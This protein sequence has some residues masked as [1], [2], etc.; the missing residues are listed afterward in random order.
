VEGCVRADLYSARNGVPHDPACTPPNTAIIVGGSLTGLATAIRLAHEGLSVTVLERGPKFGEG[1]GL[2]VDRRQLS[3]VI[4]VSAFGD[5]KH[6]ALPVIATGRESTSWKAV[7]GWLRTVALATRGVRLLT[8][9]TVISVRSEDHHAIADTFDAR[10]DADLLIGAD[11]RGSM[12]R[13]FVAPE[14]RE[15]LYSGYGLWRG[16]IDE[17]DLPASL[18]H[19]Y[20]SDGPSLRVHPRYRL[21]S[22]HVPGQDGSVAPGARAVS[23]AW[24]DPDLTLIFE[25]TGCVRSGVVRRSL[26][27]EE[28]SPIL[29]SRL[30][31]LA[32]EL[33][34]DPIGRIIRLTL[35][36]GRTF[37]TPIAEYLPTRLTSG[38]LVLVGDAAHLATPA[39]SAGLVSGLDD[40]EAL[41][42]AVRSERNG[43]LAALDVYETLRLGPAQRLA[44]ASRAWSRSYLDQA[45]ASAPFGAVPSGRV[46]A[47]TRSLR[48]SICRKR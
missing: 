22:Y 48:G 34:H 26:R 20:A 29:I 45:R 7:C 23:W 32:G 21:V 19:A 3:R 28:F 36:G 38:R 17:K 44:S 5:S 13:R 39:T 6:P 47:A 25:T 2:G 12:V 16:I 24:Y 9:H 40:A 18:A 37:A 43:G 41:G 42:D 14:N 31:R 30:D 33:W 15:P 10:F 27:P 8:N 46:A 11:G 35:G 1:T 4:G